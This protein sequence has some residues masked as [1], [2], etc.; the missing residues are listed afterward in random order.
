MYGRWV[1]RVVCERSAG[2]VLDQIQST[3]R[4]SNCTAVQAGSLGQVERLLSCDVQ[5]L[6]LLLIVRTDLR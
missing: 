4:R 2:H 3:V 1:Y 6:L 5:K